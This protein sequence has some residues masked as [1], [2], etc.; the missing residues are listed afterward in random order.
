MPNNDEKIET[1][2]NDRRDVDAVPESTG[3]TGHAVSR[4]AESFVTAA[5]MAGAS[6]LHE[7]HGPCAKPPAGGIRTPGR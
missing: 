6:A 3:A 2:R 5:A 4:H 7:F 1:Q